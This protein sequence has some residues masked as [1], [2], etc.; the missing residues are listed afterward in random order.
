VAE[1]CQRRRAAALYGAA[2]RYDDVRR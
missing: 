2:V 1:S